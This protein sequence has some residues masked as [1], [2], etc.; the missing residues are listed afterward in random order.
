VNT[1]LQGI[2][3]TLDVVERDVSHL[4]FNVCDEGAMQPGL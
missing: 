1:D 4:A 3:E 2:R